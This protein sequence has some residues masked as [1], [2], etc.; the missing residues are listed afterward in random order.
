M[1]SFG[2]KSVSGKDVSSGDRKARREILVTPPQLAVALNVGLGTVY[3]RISTGDIS[4]LEMDG[5]LWVSGSEIMSLLSKAKTW[6]EEP[7]Y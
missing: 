2:K 4:S 7:R 1:K 5:M 3:Y 6:N